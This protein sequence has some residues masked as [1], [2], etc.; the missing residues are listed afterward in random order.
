MSQSATYYVYI[1]ANDQRTIY[2]GVTNDLERRVW[3][4]K[5]PQANDRGFMAR[6]RLTML[7]HVGDDANPRDAI[8]R[9]KQLK[10]WKRARKLELFNAENPEWLDLAGDW[11]QPTINHVAGYAH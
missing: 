7:V 1:T 6:Y 3:E 10:G 11:Y 2:V 8:A 9:E 4:H 5:H